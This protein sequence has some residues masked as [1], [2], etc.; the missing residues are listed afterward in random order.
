MPYNLDIDKIKTELP[1]LFLGVCKKGR[2][3]P[4]HALCLAL[5]AEDFKNT[6][7]TEEPERFFRG[8]TIVGEQKGWTAV[9]YRGYPIGW[10]KGSE[11]MIKNHFPK[12][13]RI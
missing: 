9:L 4:S 10:G 8:E 1:G 2:F 6:T 5:V 3:E 13:L 12:Y 7:P 11:G